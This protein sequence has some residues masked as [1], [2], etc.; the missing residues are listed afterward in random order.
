MGLRYTIQ[1]KKGI[2]NE[3]L[4]PCLAALSKKTSWPFPPLYIL[5]GQIGSGLR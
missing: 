5:A 2:T 3:R 4:I 1:Y